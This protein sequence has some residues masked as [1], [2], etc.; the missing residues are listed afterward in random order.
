MSMEKSQDSHGDSA[1]Y[2]PTSISPY[3]AKTEPTRM[4]Y[5]TLVTTR[6]RCKDLN[7]TLKSILAQELPPV[8]VIVFDDGSSDGTK[9]L[10]EA[11]KKKRT[12]V[13]CI[14]RRPDLGYDIK[15][16][17]RNWN[18][19]LAEAER[20]KLD[21]SVDFTF[22]SADDCIYPSHYVRA[23]VERMN[24]DPLLAVASGTR[25]IPAPFD[26]WKP[27]EG[28]GRLIR[29]DMLRSVGFRFPEKSGYEPWLVYEAM[30]RGFRVQCINELSYEHLH[31]FG[32]SHAFVE[33]GYMPHMLGY[34]PI[35]F[36]GRCL[37]NLVSGAVPRR[38]ILNMLASYVK[39]Y[40]VI[41][42]DSFY[43]PHD[44]ELRGF[45]RSFQVERMKNVVARFLGRTLQNSSG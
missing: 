11:Y 21:R 5:W 45:I 24:H 4:S 14:L 36:L 20:E 33:W 15:R 44:P 35:F 22:I 7:R 19:C 26:G 6:N 30:R 3:A 31:Q 38:I 16:V 23:I 12:T 27:P 43:Q 1:T 18:E 13:T 39:A 34:H 42:R 2:V 9:D 8:R 17:V 28:S 10:L 32:K 29:N 37:Q 41:P 40:F 25:G